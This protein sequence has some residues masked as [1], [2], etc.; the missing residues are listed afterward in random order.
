MP[1]WGH[2]S[3]NIV[4]NSFC[5]SLHTE[6][7]EIFRF[8]NW[9]L[10]L[11]CESLMHCVLNSLDFNLQICSCGWTLK[12]LRYAVTSLWSG[13]HGG[14][15]RCFLSRILSFI[16]SRRKLSI[17]SAVFQFFTSELTIIL[18]VCKWI[19][20]A[21]LQ[22]T[23]S[24]YNASLFWVNEFQDIILLQN[25]WKTFQT[26]HHDFLVIHKVMS[27]EHCKV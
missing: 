26:Y 27:P 5:T 9:L 24:L 22:R 19:L 6:S 20:P 1:Q 4:K 2:A 13:S 23:R 10:F 16:T 17:N 18:A 12:F 3:K 14:C 21:L 7:S 8:V 25:S 15:Q 11:Y